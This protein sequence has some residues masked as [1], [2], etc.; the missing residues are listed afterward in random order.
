MQIKRFFLLQ[1]ILFIYASF[2]LL[3]LSKTTTYNTIMPLPR[4]AKA[5]ADEWN[6]LLQRR[7]ENNAIRLGNEQR[8]Q[9]GDVAFQL[10]KL[11]GQGTFGRVYEAL[12]ISNGQMLAVKVVNVG[13]AG[14]QLY[15]HCTDTKL[16]YVQYAIVTS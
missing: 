6:K 4:L 14:M 15:R 10:G 13:A 8:V 16:L 2:E 5:D 3:N 11:I 1:T 9:I 7:A 12:N